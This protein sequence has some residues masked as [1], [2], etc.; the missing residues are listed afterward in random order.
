MQMKI[1]FV[2]DESTDSISILYFNEVILFSFLPTRKFHLFWHDGTT[3][4]LNPY[5]VY[6]ES[7]IKYQSCHKNL[8][9]SIG[10][11]EFV[12]TTSPI[13]DR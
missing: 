1:E 4:K 6:E 5:Q 7:H 12:L 11:R 8:K 9:V 3:P 13:F 10:I 2:W